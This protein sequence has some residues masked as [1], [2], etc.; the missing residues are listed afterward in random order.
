MLAKFLSSLSVGALIIGACAADALNF[1]NS[2]NNIIVV[3]QDS[4]S[5]GHIEV[6]SE[7]T[8][9]TLKTS[10]VTFPFQF[11]YVEMTSD[12]NTGD[13]YIITFP[14][15]H[16]GPLLLHLNSDLA[17]VRSFDAIPYSLF[18]LQYAPKQ[19]ALYGIK[20]ISSLGR[21][22]SRFDV[23]VATHTVTAT[24]LYTLP[25][26]WFM[27]ASTF[28]VVNTRYI[29]IIRVFPSVGGKDSEQQIFVADVKNPNAPLVTLLPVRPKDA[30][31]GVFF[32]AHSPAS[33]KL[34]GGGLSN[35]AAQ[36][37]V[38]S[39]TTGAVVEV[40]F[41]VNNVMNIGPLTYISSDSAASDKLTV[42]VQRDVNTWQLYSIV[43]DRSFNIVSLIRNYTG[44]EYKSFSA[45]ATSFG[46]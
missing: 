14:N 24:E 32:V 9:S 31:I 34:F 3:R 20:V 13:A 11:P 10:A 36:V 1:R 35:G 41:N 2:G 18:D 25:D 23:D 26:K 29:G 37:V 17:L 6:V 46:N 21:A 33:G 44:S 43:A 16:Q 7:A 30:F 38:L 28:D 42:F 27:N 8:G 12:P 45:A 22:F 19:Q 4:N 39:D 40:V 15:N 5:L